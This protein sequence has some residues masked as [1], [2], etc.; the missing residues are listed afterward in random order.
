MGRTEAIAQPT[1]STSQGFGTPSGRGASPREVPATVLYVGGAPR[2]GTTL[3]DLVLG[4]L[5]GVFSGGELMFVWERGLRDNQLCGCGE[6]FR[7]CPFWLEVGRHAF[8][9]W[10]SVDLDEVLA[11]RGRLDRHSKLLAVEFGGI[12]RQTRQDLSRLTG[13]LG[14]LYSGIRSASGC[15]IIVDS[16]KRPAYAQLLRQV[17]GVR[18]RVLHC[19]RDPRGA[20]FSH[21]RSVQRP[22]IVGKV[23][24]MPRYG[25]GMAS[26]LWM[27]S[28]LFIE[29]INVPRSRLYYE[30]LTR[31]PAEALRRVL[32]EQGGEAVEGA[33][34]ELGPALA[35]AAEVA[36]PLNH[37]VAG[38][39]LRLSRMPLRIREDAEWRSG[40]SR[41]D[42]LVILAL[43]WPLFLAY[44][45]PLSRTPRARN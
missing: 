34:P 22:E 4:M 31:S 43:T 24:L 45:Y 5:P 2:S 20:G 30:Q 13:V 44:G 40:L 29:M 11:L 32:R 21:A 39:P 33:L 14:R 42:E 8:G 16:S 3:V 38:N 18:L 25:A 15:D 12:G 23:E 7:D 28:N 26:V 10:E 41:S 19:I 37:T 9:G 1:A 17:V 27:A 35:R 6:P 36:P